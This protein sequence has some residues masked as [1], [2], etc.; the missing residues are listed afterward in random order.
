MAIISPTGIDKFLANRTYHAT[1]RA[2]G[3]L[4]PFAGDEQKSELL[5]RFGFHLAPEPTHNQWGRPYTKLTDEISTVSFNV[6]D[7][8]LH[9]VLHQQT[10][11]AITR[12]MSRVMARQA[13]SYNRD[14][15]WRGRVFEPFNATAFEELFDPTQLKD[16]VAYVELNNPILQFET[17]FASFQVMTGQLRCDWYDPNVALRAFAGI[18]RYCEHM[19]RRGPAIVRRKL[20]EWGIDWRKHPYRPIDRSMFEP[21]LLRSWDQSDKGAQLTTA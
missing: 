16:M 1:S 18:D 3:K 14:T 19:N 7:N 21:E 10:V 5:D 4:R 15:G 6:M 20:F 9:N 2:T 13:D 12:L 8:H 11:D 17:P